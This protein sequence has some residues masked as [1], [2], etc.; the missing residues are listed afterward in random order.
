MLR[1]NYGER[2]ILSNIKK[3]QNIMAMFV[4]KFS[5]LMWHIFFPARLI[6]CVIILALLDTYL[7]FALIQLFFCLSEMHHAFYLPL[8]FI[9]F[10]VLYQWCLRL[11]NWKSV[12]LILKVFQYSGWVQFFLDIR[13]RIDIRIDASISIRS[14]TTK[15]GQHVHKEEELTQM[16]LNMQVLVTSLCPEH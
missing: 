11:Q 3:S 1:F 4:G 12:F 8:F 16:R 15:F 9:L 14:A 6:S 7:P 13:V 5:W 10:S 2:N